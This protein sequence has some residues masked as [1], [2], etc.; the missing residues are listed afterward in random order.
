MLSEYY[1]ICSS[2]L[3]PIRRLPPEILT[4]IFLLFIPFGSKE[5]NS[6]DFA[7]E[8]NRLKQRDLLQLA[9]VCANW[10]VL[11]LGTPAFWRILEI[12][13]MFW[14]HKLMLPLVQ[15]ALERSAN[16][17]ILV[18]L[19]APNN[20][21][22]DRSLLEFIALHCSRWQAVL[23]YMDFACFA[24]LSSIR[25]NLP[26]LESVH[27]SADLEASAD[28]T[29][30]ATAAVELIAIA[31]RLVDVTYTGPAAALKSL[32]WK[33]LRRF[34][35]PD[36][37]RSELTDALSAAQYFPP[38]MQFELRRLI[39]TQFLPIEEPL[40]PPIVS[41]LTDLTIEFALH[42][43]CAIGDVLHRLTLPHLTCLDVMVS[44]YSPNPAV[45]W[46]QTAFHSFCMR[47]RCHK[48]LTTLYLLHV[49]IASDELFN[50]L[51]ELKS[52]KALVVADHPAMVS[53]PEHVLLTD[54][55]FRRFT[56]ESTSLL[57]ELMVFGCLTLLRF[58]ETVYLDF[59][60]R[61]VDLQGA[62]FESHVRWHPG[63]ARELD[64]AVLEELLRLAQE[65]DLVGSI[66]AANEEEMQNFFY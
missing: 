43:P 8:I 37:H 35:Y 39:C 2:A 47:S 52:L 21:D 66:E 60:R 53:Q 31:P 10:R 29:T 45:T 62:G 61:L 54:H 9:Q 59:V 38:G 23:F 27:I 50:C 7:T 30:M 49:A 28:V 12:D 44:R 34:E 42:S 14:S 40:P 41:E 16:S 6:K 55:V 51:A 13:A 63:S 15:T 24:S 58:D 1:A 46:D 22:V 57:P 25:G 32:P 48:T 11:A 3:S 4:Q 26:L 56:D 19:G 64:P 65:K 17:P 36:L 5:L 33:Q 20:V 18:R